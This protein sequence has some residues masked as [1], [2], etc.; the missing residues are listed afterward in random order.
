MAKEEANGGGSG[1]QNGSSCGDSSV[2]IRY[3]NDCQ[4]MQLEGFFLAVGHAA[5]SHFYVHVGVGVGAGAGAGAGA[6]VGHG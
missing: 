1:G 5:A 3:S 6:G 2:V 4:R